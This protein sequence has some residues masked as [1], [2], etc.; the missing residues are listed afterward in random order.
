MGQGQN[1]GKPKGR[2]WQIVFNG[3]SIVWG[4]YINSATRVP[5][6]FPLQTL[7]LLASKHYQRSF[8]LNPT[9]LEGPVNLGVDGRQFVSIRAAEYAPFLPDILICACGVNNI[10]INNNLSTLQAEATTCADDLATLGK[11]II[12]GTIMV[13]DLTSGQNTIRLA[14][15]AW[16]LAGGI[17]SIAAS[18]GEICDPSSDSRMQDDSDSDW[19][20]Q[21]G[22]L[23][24]RHPT[25]TNSGTDIGG[26]YG[27]MAQYYARS[28]QSVIGRNAA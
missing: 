26:G 24:G 10:F 9:D 12:F 11:P 3:D 18:G 1:R 21:V 5:N 8:R 15:N 28:I 16:L 27:V 19:F 7:N 20:Q 6:P 14:Y 13:S 25:P 17:P 22:D 23:P 2:S 4:W